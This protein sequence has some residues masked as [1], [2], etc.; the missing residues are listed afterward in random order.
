MIPIRP[1]LNLGGHNI[2][3]YQIHGGDLILCVPSFY[4]RNIRMKPD[5]IMPL[6][7][8]Q[9]LE[10]DMLMKIMIFIVVII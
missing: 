4:T 10:K 2:N 8:L 1:V 3:Q 9:Q 6:K 5:S 7:L